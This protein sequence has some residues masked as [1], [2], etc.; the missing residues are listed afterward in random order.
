MPTAFIKKLA[1]E[2]KGSAKSLEKKWDEAKARAK[3]EG[4][5]DDYA[6]ITGIFKR[7][8][9]VTASTATDQFIIAQAEAGFATA[10]SAAFTR[11]F[12]RGATS[13]IAATAE[14]AIRDAISKAKDVVIGKPFYFVVEFNGRKV[15]FQGLISK[16]PSA[17]EQKRGIMSS[18]KLT[19][20]RYGPLVRGSEP[21]WNAV[22]YVLD[23]RNTL[24]DGRGLPNSV[25]EDEAKAFFK[26]CKLPVPTPT[27]R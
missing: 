25:S 4:R 9:G 13:V 8:A 1:K 14:D 11:T 16:L 22:H 7:M 21:T 10:L 5:G 20:L 6:Y 2:G 17:A 18:V 26:A 24:K 3:E 12:Q 27:T 19:T 15:P 23:G